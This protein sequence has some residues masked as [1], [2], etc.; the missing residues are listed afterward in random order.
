MGLELNYIEG[1]TPVD[2]DEKQGLRI[3]S[4]TTR[5]ELD[6]F[7]QLNIEKAVEW[8]MRRKFNQD[9]IIT[10]QFVKELHF[11][12][13]EDVWK[14]AGKFRTTNKNIGVDWQY[15]SVSLKQLLDDCKFW[16][17]HET[18]SEDEI[19]VRFSH[20]IV[21]IHCFPNGN[22]RHSRLIADVIISNILNRPVF[23]WGSDA[24]VRQGE[25][26]K[27]YI[28]AIQEAD[29]GNIVPLLEFARS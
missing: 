5:E 27:G 23:S 17:K 15:I 24:L 18:Y 20:R 7:E 26:R 19:A 14:W 22:G 6:E 2:E 13:Y 9:F 12:M 28:T 1:Q 21:S 3:P 25:V 29:R 16:I 11:R 4:I 8:T 10:E